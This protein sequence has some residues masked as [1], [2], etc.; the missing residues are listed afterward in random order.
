MHAKI[1]LRI[2]ASIALF[3]AIFHIFMPLL[4]PE[5]Y[6]APLVNGSGIEIMKVFNFLTALVCLGMSAIAF[7]FS[8]E[9]VSSRFGRVVCLY[10]ASIGLLRALLEII[11]VGIT[12]PVSIFIITTTFIAGLCCI[13]AIMKTQPR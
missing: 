1:Y 10:F 8:S 11:C 12:D 3:Y 5:L 4:V 6:S 7:V 13:L 9:L 2:S